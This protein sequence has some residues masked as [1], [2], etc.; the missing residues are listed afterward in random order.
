M[1]GWIE[2]WS[3]DG[4]WLVIAPGFNVFHKLIVVRPDGTGAHVL[5]ACSGGPGRSASG[6][7]WVTWLPDGKH[8]AYTQGPNLYVIDA[9]GSGRVLVA[10]THSRFPEFAV[11]PDGSTIAYVDGRGQDYNRD[12]YVVGVDGSGRRLVAHSSTLRYWNPTWRPTPG[13]TTR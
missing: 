10:R 12:L 5:P 7:G 2:G 11:S 4:R 8:L 6:C 9:D 1:R 3:P 13:R